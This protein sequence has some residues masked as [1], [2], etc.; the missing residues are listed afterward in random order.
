MSGLNAVSVKRETIVLTLV[1]LR[2]RRN[3]VWR[4]TARM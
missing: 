4:N 2:G 1:S 3:W